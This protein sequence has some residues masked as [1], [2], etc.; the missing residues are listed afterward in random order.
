[1]KFRSRK[2]RVR[3]G[4]PSCLGSEQCCAN[5]FATVGRKIIVQLM[6]QINRKNITGQLG[7]KDF[8]KIFQQ[9]DSLLSYIEKKDIYSLINNK[10]LRS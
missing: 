5:S 10:Q 8:I 1:M 7:I 4:R 3:L 6:Q 9:F 2:F